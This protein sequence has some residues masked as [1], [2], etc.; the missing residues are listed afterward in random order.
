[1]FS[2]ADQAY[3]P[4]AF[5]FK[6]S[7]AY[8]YCADSSF[9]EVSGIEAEWSTKDVVEGGENRFVHRLPTQ[10]K[11]PLLTLKR[12]VADSESPLVIWC[13]ETL[14]LGLVDVIRPQPIVVHLL[15]ENREPL[16]AWFFDHAY[17]VKWKVES[18][19]SQKNE[20]AIEE[21]QLHYNYS[22]RII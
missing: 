4:T 6:L 21:V 5:H 19:D 15:D 9:K 16:R 1:M 18:F 3:P 2:T 14:E 8:V 10:L 12:G 20:V 11:H 17:P 22:N 7:I 13:K